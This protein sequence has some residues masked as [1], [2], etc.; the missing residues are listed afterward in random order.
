MDKKIEITYARAF[1]CI[2]I[3]ALHSFP[4]LIN[5]PHTTDFSK[6]ISSF[7]RILFLFATPAFIVLSEILLSMRYSDGL[8]K[9]FFKKGLN[10]Y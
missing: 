7:L 3:V 2:S 8:P 4:G 10:L 6:S 1:F 5:D 9:G